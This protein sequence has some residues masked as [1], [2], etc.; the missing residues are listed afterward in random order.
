MST[1]LND[2]AYTRSGDKGD[3]SNIG[4]MAKGPTEFE[5]LRAAVTPE[6]VKGFF[7]D[8]VTGEVHVYEL[9]LIESLQVVM[10]GALGGGATQ[11]LRF[12]ETGKS[13][14]ALMSR[15]PIPGGDDD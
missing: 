1:L 8:L 6:A 15:F 3:V 2:L 13:M 10:Y 11:T 9:P 4:I 5:V 7:G 14:A 12:D